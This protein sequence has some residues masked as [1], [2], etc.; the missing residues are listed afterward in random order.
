MRIALIHENSEYRRQFALNYLGKH[1]ISLFS[2]KL[3]TEEIIANISNSGG[4]DLAI[5]S[6]DE[7]NPLAFDYLKAIRKAYRRTTLVATQSSLDNSQSSFEAGSIANT[8]VDDEDVLNGFEA[9]E[10]LV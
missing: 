6:I 2:S 9:L 5:V 8:L 4:V 3:Y 1:E 10:S 7:N